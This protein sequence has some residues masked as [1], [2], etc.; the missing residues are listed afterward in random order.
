VLRSIRDLEHVVELEPRWAEA[1]GQL[2]KSQASMVDAGF[3]SDP[4]WYEKAAGS[5]DRARSLDTDD[6]IVNFGLGNLHLVAGRKHE[7]HECFLATRRRAPNFAMNYHYIG[8]L[9]RLCDMLDEAKQ[10]VALSIDLDPSVI[11]PMAH[12]VRLCA[13]QGD[14]PGAR[15]WLEQGLRRFPNHDRLVGIE[16]AILM[17]EGR[18]AEALVLQDKVVSDI[19]GPGYAARAFALLGL[20]ERDRARALVPLAEAYASVDMDA[21]GDFAGVLAQL[22]E[23]DKAFRYLDR[24]VALGNDTLTRF[25]TDVYRPLH[26][27]PR[28]GRFIAGME[29]RIDGY[30]RDFRWPLPD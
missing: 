10:A 22:G 29:R 15:E 30:R 20:G 28:W 23:T 25:R 12:M 3:D 18:F 14:F 5:L 17:S 27:D 11:W 26:D 19:S 6:P 21:A 13:I 4:R 9:F 8:Y 1:W 2:G 7:A 24:A 16:A